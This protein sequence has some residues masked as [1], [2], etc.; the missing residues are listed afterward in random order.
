M[1]EN[2]LWLCVILEDFGHQRLGKVGNC[3]L[4]F[5]SFYFMQGEMMAKHGHRLIDI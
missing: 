3:T 4:S 1:N 5:A 2:N